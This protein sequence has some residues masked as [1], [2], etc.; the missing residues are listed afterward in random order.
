MKTRGYY[1]IVDSYPSTIFKKKE[2][3]RKK[4]IVIVGTVGMC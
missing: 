2:K 3:K 1:T 4:D